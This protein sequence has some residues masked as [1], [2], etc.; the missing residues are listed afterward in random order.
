MY[1]LVLGY[2]GRHELRAIDAAHRFVLGAIAES[3]RP[4]AP[5]ITHRGTS[6]LA[7]GDLKCSGNSMRCKRDF[8]LYHGTLL[9]DFP[10]DLI[11]E[12]LAMPPRQPAY[13]AGRP[14]AGFVANLPVSAVALCQSLQGAF[15][16]TQR[17]NHWAA[18]RT[19]K[20]AREKYA[21]REWSFRH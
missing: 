6:D 18:A 8:F 12:C 9:Y 20:L 14:H 16:A 19:E 13:R 5:A 11:A 10:L 17:L 2:A 7:I 4:A 1:A 15:A 21:T 3:L